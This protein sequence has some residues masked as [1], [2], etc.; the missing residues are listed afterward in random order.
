MFQ[1]RTKGLMQLHCLSMAVLL[2]IFFVL[3][4]LAC[5]TLIKDLNL[6]Y[7][8]YFWAI[9]CSG[10]LSFFHYSNQF[11]DLAYL[12]WYESLKIT[13]GQILSL[14][15]VLFGLLFAVKDA[16]INK[17]VI[18]SFIATM[19]PICWLI[20]HFLPKALASL[21]FDFNTMRFCILVGSAKSCQELQSWV[22]DHSLIGIKVAGY[23]SMHQEDVTLHIPCMGTVS[24]LNQIIKDNKINQVILLESYGSKE[25]V[26]QIIQVSDKNSCKIWIYNPWRDYFNKPI[27]SIQEGGHTFFTF[28]DEPLENP[29]NRLFKRILDTAIA[30]PIVIFILPF[31][32]VLVK[33]FQIKEAP[34]D[35]FFKQVRMG[36]NNRPFTIYKFR[37][38]FDNK[39]KNENTQASTTDKRIFKFGHI[40]RKTSIDEF[41]QF[42]NVLLGQM[43][44]VGPR[45][46]YIGHD[47]L[48]HTYVP[49]Y[50][51]R[52]FVKPGVT[53]L[54]QIKGY[55]GEI[56]D[57]ELLKERTSYDLTYIDNW[58]L[59]LDLVIILKTIWQV[60]FPPK[61]AY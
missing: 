56:T 60:I 49:H 54:A 35:L 51:Q 46:H 44:V 34:G 55:R 42:I 7:R 3:Y 13:N 22:L 52:N 31:L 24:N 26:D 36:R 11:F 30:L 23:V 19:W 38:M 28:K 5:D 15:I 20:N 40:I 9:F 59:G 39:Y 17:L 2:P 58:S 1:K 45:P 4:S 6:N 14:A 8:L 12:K 53:G 47:K 18:M 50:R 43:S 29:T 32:I 21:F 57:L 48:F 61:T 25:W 37:S 27:L 10:F 16:R 41:P 33:I